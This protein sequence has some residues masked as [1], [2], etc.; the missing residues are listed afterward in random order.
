VSNTT[1]GNP[2]TLAERAS[3][4]TLR[5]FQMDTDVVGAVQSSLNLFAGKV[6]LPIEL[7]NLQGRGGLSTQVSLGYSSDVAYAVQTWNVEAPTGILGLGWSLEGDSIERDLRGSLSPYDDA[8][9]LRRSDGSATELHLLS[10]GAD[11]WVFEA[12]SFDF[13]V[14][15]Y[16]P[17]RDSWEITGIDGLIKR[18]GDSSN[19]RQRGVHWGGATGNWSDASIQ[20]GQG[21]YTLAW[22]LSSISNTYGDEIR[23][24][25]TE[26]ADDEVRI[27]PAGGLSYTR[28]KYLSG[29][30]DPAGRQVRFHY[31]DKRN[32][33]AV[34]EYVPPHVEVG[35]ERAYQDRYETRFLDAIEV[36]HPGQSQPTLT[37]RFCYEL[38]RYTDAVGEPALLFKRYLSGFALINDQRKLLPGMRFTY[39][40][41]SADEFATGAL[42]R[43]VFPNG[44]VVDYTYQHRAIG[45]T[46][47]KHVATRDQTGAGV[48]RVWIGPN[49]TVIA[50]YDAL[51][52][53]R[54]VVSV[55]DWNGSWHPYRAIDSTLEDDLDLDS[56]AVDLQD[57]FFVIS[58]RFGGHVVP[59]QV[60]CQAVRRQFGRYGVW[61]AVP[62]QAP[63]LPRPGMDYQVAAGAGFVALAVNDVA[64]VL[65]YVW[66]AR[67]LAWQRSSLAQDG[68]GQY[69][70]VAR[71][72]L[73]LIA[74]L[75]PI[76]GIAQ[77]Q[78]IA[79]E[80]GL[81]TWRLP[82][83]LDSFA[84]S[85]H[86]DAPKPSF[87]LSETFASA[88]FITRVDEERKQF[89]YEVRLYRWDRVLQNPVLD[90]QVYRDLP[91]DSE[92]PFLLGAAAGSLMGNAQN[93]FRFNGTTWVA[94]RLGDFSTSESPHFAYGRDL[95]VVT[96]GVDTA[97]MSYRPELD[98]FERTLELRYALGPRQPT[99][100]GNYLT[101][102]NRIYYR[103]P[104]GGLRYLRDLP[105]DAEQIVNDGDRFIAY[106]YPDGRSFVLL[107]KNGEAAPLA[108]TLVGRAFVPDAGASGTGLF[109][110]TAFATY[111]GPSFDAAEEIHL[112]RS[113]HGRVSGAI[114]DYVVVS[115]RLRTAEDTT[116]LTRLTYPSSGT[117]GPFGLGAQY[118][119][120]E[121]ARGTDGDDTPFGRER[122]TYFDGLAPSTA[123]PGLPYALFNG[124]LREKQTY[125][126][127]GFLLR[128]EGNT[129]D[130]TRSRVDA[131]TGA[132]RALFG[133]YVRLR[134]E[135]ARDYDP[136]QPGVSLVH[137]R[138][139][140]FSAS[141]GLPVETIENNID[142][143]GQ[144]LRL[145]MRSE[146]AFE[147]YPDLAALNWLDQVALATRLVDGVIVAREAR[148]WGRLWPS[149]L[150]RLAPLVQLQARHAGA[151]LSAAQWSGDV[152]PDAADWLTLDTVIDRDR[153]GSAVAQRD[154]TGVSS[155]LL[156]DAEGRFVVAQWIGA[157]RTRGQV[158]Y[159]GFE[160]YESI[161][162]WTLGGSTQNLQAAIRAGDAHCGDSALL[163]AGGSA[164]GQGLGYS[165]PISEP[166]SRSYVFAA[167]VKTPSAAVGGAVSAQ[168]RMQVGAAT[169]T[170]MLEPTD[171]AWRYVWLLL[172]VTGSDSEQSLSVA[173]DNPG[174]ADLWVDDVRFGPAASDFRASAWDTL[175]R[176][177]DA[178]TSNGQTVRKR[179]GDFDN[180]VIEV[181]AEEALVAFWSPQQ[182]WPAA[183]GVAGATSNSLLSLKPQTFATLQSFVL[184]P[185]WSADWG[186]QIDAFAPHAGRLEH[187]GAGEAQIHYADLGDTS[188][189]WFVSARI[190]PL[191][192]V[193]PTGSYGL[194]TG[195]VRLECDE[196]LAGWRLVALPARS[197][198]ARSSFA[199]V[200]Q[201]PASAATVLDQSRVDADIVAA[202][203][204]AAAPLTE[205]VHIDVIDAG[206]RWRLSTGGDTGWTY[207]LV[208]RAGVIEVARR[209]RQLLLL[210][211]GHTVV[212]FADGRRLFAVDRAQAPDPQAGIFAAADV[213]FDQ[214]S[215]GTHPQVSLDYQ[216]GALLTRQSQVVADTS[217][218]ATQRFYDPLGRAAVT[219]QGADLPLAG[220]ALLDY[221]TNLAIYDWSTAALSGL[222]AEQNTDSGA[223]AYARTRYEASP[224]GRPVQLGLPG[225][226]FAIP[227]QGGAGH[228]ARTRYGLS[229]GRF[230]EPVGAL[231]LEESTTADGQRVV[232]LRT[233]RQDVVI[234]AAL[235]GTA[236]DRYDLGRRHYDPA[237]R[238]IELQSPMGWSDQFEYDFTGR[239][240]RTRHA[241]D[242]ADRRML[243]DR[244][245]RLRFALMPDGAASALPYYQ[246]FKYDLYSRPTSAGVALGSWDPAQLALHAEDPAWPDLPAHRSTEF[247]GLWRG[248]LLA[249]GLPAR[250]QRSLQDESPQGVDPVRVVEERYYDIWVQTI[251]QH[252]RISGS[253]ADSEWQVGYEYD[254]LSK[255]L[256]T[257]YP[258]L[259][260]AAALSVR[261]RYDRVGR[262]AELAFDGQRHAYRYDR[263]GLL[264]E[265]RWQR[266]DLSEAVRRLHYNSAAWPVLI[267]DPGLRQTLR[268]TEGGVGERGFY[269][270]KPAAIEVAAR[271]GIAAWSMRL[272]YNTKGALSACQIDPGSTDA[273]RYDANGNLLKLGAA[274]LSYSAAEHDRT[275]TV[276][277]EG[278][279]AAMRYRADGALAQRE[280]STQ[281]K[282]N[283]S[284]G[285][286][287]LDS[288]PLRV[289]RGV[290][291]AA[292]LQRMHFDAG[293]QRILRQVN[294]AST[295]YVR[296]LSGDPLLELAADGSWRWQVYGPSGAAFMGNGQEWAYLSRDS[297]GSIRA[298]V[299]ARSQLLAGYDFL[300]F[301]AALRAPFGPLRL[302]SNYRFISRELDPVELYDL[303]ARYYDPSIGRFLSQDPKFQQA[304]PYVYAANLPLWLEDP[305]G[306]E[307]LSILFGLLVGT[308]INAAINAAIK[309]AIGVGVGAAVGAATGAIS[310]VVEIVSRDLEGG[311]AAGV[312]FGSL[313][314]GL[315]VG[316]VGGAITGGVGAALP[317][318]VNA[319]LGT[320]AL[321]TGI[322]AATG[323]A[324]GA[325][326]GAAESAGQAALLG[327]DVGSA[328]WKGALSAAIGAGIGGFL[329]ETIE[330]AARLGRL[331]RA[332]FQKTAADRWTVFAAST[333]GGAAGG[334]TS[335]GVAGALN[336]DSAADVFVSSLQSAALGFLG[337]LPE[338]RKKP[339]RPKR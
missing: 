249:V 228:T 147:H 233:L 229:D 287:V 268:Y 146:Y 47:L 336:G 308:A 50:R 294:G 92:T 318:S 283:L 319:S 58:A 324:T 15:T 72:S 190:R 63:P 165:A 206:Q 221:T 143:R 161:Q 5:N 301:G 38:Q 201:L 182:T 103:Q 137:W 204:A 76:T 55:F 339:W 172:E 199:R 315:A 323:A 285:Y 101:I 185:D 41:R 115:S 49:Y 235:A 33:D 198:L 118:A 244:A 311:E 290:A 304:S 223:F 75:D 19:A 338:L 197:V 337:S 225:A 193:A 220:A 20:L 35:P 46:Q 177:I 209:D 6:G 139:T 108:E 163:I 136:A 203:T 191:G 292:I 202:F 98:A 200:L 160:R 253:T 277:T 45:G 99:V 57:D 114:Y 278:V 138:E 226:D 107:L 44:A 151:A 307:L 65:R 263:N 310:G 7:I 159:L 174:S 306:E 142:S 170:H 131:R 119:Q 271:G 196:A 281:P 270:G 231:R 96:S 23:Y 245:G 52:Q 40:N 110:P 217:V 210:V 302:Q 88:I 327:E 288:A 303:R 224:L 122:Y 236:P 68:G 273:F 234:E 37:V 22:N 169:Q 205:L 186:G 333:L 16:F 153:F 240:T 300:P 293:G 275:Q 129:W 218:V 322:T 241:N 144:A 130:V 155:S 112:H 173:I 195:D 120:V 2:Q 124:L 243:Y 61:D 274:D 71:G 164:Q 168:L 12:E 95:A 192:A 213:S 111:V 83:R 128:S 321:N 1:T 312:F 123:D 334:A 105:P 247:D 104:R 66:D 264:V 251:A 82:L 36:V 180:A 117:T 242:N 25:Y 27:G 227:P 91:T 250:S 10:R 121:L 260:P 309:V 289:E 314:L 175:F 54:L 126:A 29:I 316:T 256:A 257:H 291:P 70:I 298:L 331:G 276:T 156:L 17:A 85:P 326:L 148:L 24:A 325:V 237:G 150:A 258:A 48:P 317:S 43:A 127:D 259:G 86:A 266:P 176:P 252:Y 94:A 280:V 18:F 89:D 184:G 81:A 93:L 97:V 211:L 73:A 272:D 34:R 183:S 78:L 59:E 26:F 255:V 219:S 187:R 330:P 133:A 100:A 162:G 335:G 4:P 87:V 102:G 158:G 31:G 208:L 77:L 11:A 13:S 134:R 189:D 181:D 207:E 60:W 246:W 239:R 106:G 32:D 262:T 313:G 286:D 214:L 14:I 84:P 157:D 149:G 8:F 179:Y 167:W 3:V 171:G 30:S 21:T 125:T 212:A 265:E 238:L 109:G 215:V 282:G 284:M 79:L 62:L 295:T 140:T 67:S 113:L 267:E 178:F 9:F 42:V 135:E 39:E 132:G 328:A 145:A 299:D 166:V 152:D 297:I 269:S 320:V 332:A 232:T 90:W 194:V 248:D 116:Q 51:N 305:N 230:G 261:Q 53:R 74:R 279:S 188:G 80:S 56:L 154:A 254:N 69:S 28:A 141:N 222:V 329:S 216:D 296:S 64:E